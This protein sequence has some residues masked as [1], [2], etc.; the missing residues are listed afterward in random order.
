[1]RIDETYEPAADAFSTDDYSAVDHY[2]PA[3]ADVGVRFEITPHCPDDWATG[4]IGYFNEPGSNG[5]GRFWRVS[6][7]GVFVVLPDG[8]EFYTD[9]VRKLADWLLRI[10]PGRAACLECWI[11]ARGR[12][13]GN[14]G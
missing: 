8:R 4:D 6:A 7:T 5:D 11:H 10:P 3:L 1:M 2:T 13:F 9:T 14:G 12:L